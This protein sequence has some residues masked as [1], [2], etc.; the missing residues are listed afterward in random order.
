MLVDNLQDDEALQSSERLRTCFRKFGL[1]TRL[2]MF[3]QVLEKFHAPKVGQAGRRQRYL[4][5]VA[6]AHGVHKTCE[7]P[8]IGIS[9]G[10]DM[11]VEDVLQHLFGHLNDQGVNV[12]RFQHFAPLVVDDLT[13]LG[14]HVIVFQEMLA[15]VEI[16]GFDLALGVFNGSGNHA[17]L[18]GL[19]RLHA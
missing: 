12:V 19:A 17:V 13:L 5:P 1:V 18:N 8:I 2:Q 9:L 7:V 11:G 6:L 16:M 10:V 15:D 14:H 4:D 3:A